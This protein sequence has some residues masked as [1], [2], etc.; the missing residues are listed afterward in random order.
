MM[1]LSKKL[2]QNYEDNVTRSISQKK[3]EFWFSQV[4]VCESLVSFNIIKQHFI[5]AMKISP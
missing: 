3:I 5:I 4:D 1:I 2:L